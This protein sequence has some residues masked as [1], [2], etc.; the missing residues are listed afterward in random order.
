LLRQD[1]FKEALQVAEAGTELFKDSVTMWQTKLQV[2]IDSKSPDVEMRFEE[3]FAHLK[4]QV[5]ELF[6]L[7][8]IFKKDLFLL[9]Y[10]HE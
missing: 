8:F 6:L 7:Y 4:P 3:A 9:F 5:C 2:L 1:L 10:V